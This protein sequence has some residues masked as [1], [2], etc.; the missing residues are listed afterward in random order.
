MGRGRY[1]KRAG[2]RPTFLELSGNSIFYSI[3]PRYWDVVDAD[4]PANH[5]G[6]NHRIEADFSI[7]YNLLQ[8]ILTTP[9]RRSPL[10]RITMF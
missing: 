2:A 7:D 4:G 5:G 10:D 1:G 8:T 3:S 9:L 6:C